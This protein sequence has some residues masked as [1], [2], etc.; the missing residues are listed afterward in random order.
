MTNRQKIIFGFAG[1][2]LIA[3]GVATGYL[4]TPPPGQAN[5]I[6][7]NQ[8]NSAV[9][10]RTIDLPGGAISIGSETT[11]PE[12]AGSYE[13]EIAPFNIDAHEVTN[14]QFAKFVEATGYITSAERAKEIGFPENGS[15]IF[16]EQQWQFVPGATWRE[17]E[18]P[19][20]TFDP[21][22]PVVHMSRRDASA[23]AEWV[24]RRLPT[25]AEF[26]YAARAGNFE[27]LY[28][29][30]DEL[31]PEGKHMANTWQ[32]VFP[33]ADMGRDGFTGLAPIGCFPANNFGLHDM[34]G[35]VW[36]WTSST[37]YPRHNSQEEEQQVNNGQ[38]FDP[39]QPGLPVGVLKG[40]S[41]LCSEN[42][43]RRYRPSAR[44]PQDLEMGTNHIGFRTAGD[45][46]MGDTQ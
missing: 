34:I 44:H 11:Y 31:V 3:G 4:L 10:G 35:N 6:A 25:E 46:S 8:C 29:W 27:T 30:G 5:S 41:F 1:L 28:A 12:E 14:G 7:A 17:P 20:S 45:P 19:G 36:E 43:C 26:E 32:G 33:E 13:S 39:N 38:G 22:E 40:G 42:Y 16:V 37:Y 21:L 24:G 15:A 2:A 23:Y 18:G 9:L